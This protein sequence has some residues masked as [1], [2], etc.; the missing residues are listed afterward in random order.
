MKRDLFDSNKVSSCRLTFF[1]AAVV[2]ASNSN[3]LTSDL[4][5]LFFRLLD[6][7]DLAHQ[8]RLNATNIEDLE[9]VVL[10][11][12]YF[13]VVEHVD[14]ERVESWLANVLKTLKACRGRIL[15]AGVEAMKRLLCCKIKGIGRRLLRQLS[16][17][18]GEK[19]RNSSFL[20]AGGLK[21]P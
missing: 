21:S 13:L 2:F 8:K 20:A 3:Y 15:E 14:Y 7:Q 17:W 12:E 9:R 5:F 19:R 18:G 11:V 16:G 10:T 1:K 6:F 4:D